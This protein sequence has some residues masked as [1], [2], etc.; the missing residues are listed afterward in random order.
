[1]RPTARRGRPDA[2][3]RDAPADETDA[4][5]RL[6]RDAAERDMTVQMQDFVGPRH[7]EETRPG[8]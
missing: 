1:M 2:E 5:R 3:K 4:R 6:E 8:R 7:G